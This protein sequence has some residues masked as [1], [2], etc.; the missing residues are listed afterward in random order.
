MRRLP[1]LLVAVAVAATSCAGGVHREFA[2]YYDPAGHFSA[3]LP[4]DNQIRVLPPETGGDQAGP[5]LLSGVQSVPV[6]PSPAAGLGGLGVEPAG[7]QDR[8]AYYV[9]AFTS[10]LLQ[11][12]E[13]L[14]RLYTSQ[15]GVDVKVQEPVRIGDDTGLLVVADSETEGGVR[16]SVASGFLLAGGVGY[17]IA[18]AFPA[19]AWE[20]EREDFLSVLSSF[21]TEV[22]PAV[23]AIPV[24]GP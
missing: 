10:D 20:S 16:F 19:G 9:F 7:T 23:R 15:P 8:T 21:R 13:D 11:D 12:E 18:A 22:P 17:W 6:Q 5:Q 3:V 24:G 2:R 1:V 4:R 14:A